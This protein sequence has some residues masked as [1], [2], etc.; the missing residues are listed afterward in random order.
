MAGERD[1]MNRKHRAVAGGLLLLSAAAANAAKPHEHGVARLDI[2]VEAARVTL[3]LEVP[4]DSLLGFE[5]EP[6]SDAERALADAAL[7]RLRDSATLFRIDPAAHCTLAKVDLQSAALGLGG[8]PASVK[9]G[10]ADLD[11]TF[12][13]V[14]K[15]GSRAGFV[16]VGL[17]DAFARL[18]RI[19]V[20]AATRKGQLKATLKRPVKRVPLAR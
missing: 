10:H 9:E 1:R 12:D 19:D 2:A 14:C 11:A 20:Q 7:A 17:F 15:D 18:Q 4:L 3:L 5:R 8:E 13:F 6:R 16:E